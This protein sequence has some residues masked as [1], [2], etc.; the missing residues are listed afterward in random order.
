ML[1]TCL[2]I[3]LTDVM[4]FIVFVGCLSYV[5]YLFITCLLICCD[6]VYFVACLLLFVSGNASSLR[7]KKSNQKD[8]L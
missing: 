4:L 6:V 3:E 7:I 2:L 8:T 1:L 5:V